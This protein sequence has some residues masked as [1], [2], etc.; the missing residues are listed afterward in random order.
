MRRSIVALAAVV[1]ALASGAT[2]AAG[3]RISVGP[4]VDVSGD[5]LSQNETP[6]A[7]NPANPANMITGANDWNYND[8]CAVN[9]TSDGGTTWTPTLPDGFL[10]GVTKFTNDPLVDGT[11]AYDAGGDPTIAFSPDGK[12]AYYVCQAFNFTSPYDIALLLNRSTDGGFTWQKTNLVQVSTFNGNG[13]T[14]GSNGKFADHENLHVDPV[15][16]YVY[17]TWA[18]FSGVQGTHSPVYV[19]VS[20]DRGTTWLLNKVTVGNV[21]NNQDQRVVTDQW[22]NAYLVFD[23]GVNGGKGLTVLYASK[24][25]NGGATWSAPVQFAALADPVC[26]FPPGCFNISGGQFRAG[27]TYPAPA[28]DNARNRLDVLIA[29]I[30]GT[31]AQMYLYSLKPDLT[32]DFTT[33][34]PARAGDQFMGE[35][36]AAP[37]GRLDASYWDRSYSGNKL[38]DL[39]YATSA[40][41][42]N[43]WRTARVTRSGYDPSQWG[44]PQGTGFR[45]F[46]GDYNGIAS[47]NT[48]AAM[49]W[50]GVAP[51][52]P[53]NLEIDFAKATP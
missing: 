25:T 17:V 32:L 35:L 24:S 7:V 23:N 11:G 15:N 47:T 46:I 45:P 26:V 21:K 33:Q 1:A 36:S 13:T 8:G 37:N 27:G 4:V 16:G 43:T 41:G 38:A 29:D 31:Y 30:R 34:L 12:V 49:T 2:A 50:T 42:G 51:P 9:A 14:S 52:Q 44:V 18:E 40:D 10:P 28:F 20:H 39:T 19:A 48:F 6:I 22:G 3:T 5:Q 53:Y